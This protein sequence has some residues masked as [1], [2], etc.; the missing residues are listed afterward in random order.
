ML[1]LRNY[2]KFLKLFNIILIGIGICY[3]FV[4]YFF[5][6]NEILFASMALICLL[7]MLSV[8]ES[9]QRA[10]WAVLST[11]FLI[12][13]FANI[14]ELAYLYPIFIN[15]LL[16]TIFAISLKD[17]A[18]ITKIAKKQASLKGKILD[19]KAISYT[20]NLTKIWIIFF[21][22]N[23][24]ISFILIFLDDKIYWTLYCGVISYILIG[25]LFGAE[26][27]YRKFI[28]QVE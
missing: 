8:Q 5:P 21:I 3:P 17:E 22:L 9:Y 20:R 16:G 19:Q 7:R 2:P 11:I 18:I 12:Y 23:A 1:S 4:L 6:E 26:I 27:L 10:I 13:F 15:A 28:L 25:I 24:F 14:Q